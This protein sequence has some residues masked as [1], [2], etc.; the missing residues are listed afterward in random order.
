MVGAFV[1]IAVLAP[2]VGRVTIGLLTGAAV[3][4]ALLACLRFAPRVRGGATPLLLAASWAVL[5]TC[6]WKGLGESSTI[7]AAFVFLAVPSAILAARYG[8]QTGRI[9]L[10]SKFILAACITLVGL[11]MAMLVIPWWLPEYFI[12]QHDVRIHSGEG[13][14]NAWLL[15]A[16][17]GVVPLLVQNG[18]PGRVSMLHPL[19][20]GLAVVLLVGSLHA[21]L[22]LL[23]WFRASAAER[24]VGRA[25]EARDRY[26]HTLLDWRDFGL[27]EPGSWLDTVLRRR[28]AMTALDAGQIYGALDWYPPAKYGGGPWMDLALRTWNGRTLSMLAQDRCRSA[29]EPP[30]LYVDF[31]LL[32]RGEEVERYALDAWGRVWRLEKDLVRLI[33]RPHELAP[34]TARDMERCGNA[35]AVLASDGSVFASEPVPWLNPATITRVSRESRAV[36]WEMLPSGRGALVATDFGDVYGLGEVP[37]SLSLPEEPLFPSRIVVDLELDADGGAY[38][39][40]DAHGAIHAHGE[41]DIPY[42]KPAVPAAPYWEDPLAIDLERIPQP[43]QGFYITLTDGEVFPVMVQPHRYVY[44]P[45]PGHPYGA[46]DLCVTGEDVPWVLLANGSVEVMP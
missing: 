24:E 41:P 45:D 32:Q 18:T 42:S 25:R 11:G 2:V 38:Y 22:T 9:D 28:V 16:L 40:L 12:I 19:V 39:L 14:S 35:W 8:A 7:A 6:L 33:W 36:D 31:E 20:A 4:L 23:G 21:G 15:L 44:R 10:P 30:G 43:K 37:E 17:L 46:V 26:V 5:A 3:L 34:G 1:T 27:A 13:L 29:F